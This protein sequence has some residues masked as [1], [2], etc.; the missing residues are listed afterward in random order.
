VPDAAELLELFDR[1]LR[2]RVVGALPA[3]TTVERDGPLLRVA[4]TP[5]GGFVECADPDALRSADTDAL[6][7]GE[8]AFFAARGEPFEW[9]LYGHDGVVGLAER[10]LAAGFV[11]DEPETVVIAPVEAVPRA[12][13]LPDGV[14]LREVRERAD[15]DRIDELERTVW[16]DE[17]PLAESLAAELAAD[18]EGIAIVVAEDGA[19]VL[20]AGWVRFAP[21]A[22]FAT[23]WGGATLPAWRRRGLYRATVARRAELAARRGCRYLQVDASAESRPILERLGFVPVTTATGFR[24]SPR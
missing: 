3:G 23:L 7:R 1:R 11:P 18:P 17:E 15:L 5:F 9:K 6:V 2:G 10:L 16:G 13:A 14:T 12:P 4:G 24:W 19:T 8:V 20:C 21:A 22:G